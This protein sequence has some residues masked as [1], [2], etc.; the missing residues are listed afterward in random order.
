MQLFVSFKKNTLFLGERQVANTFFFG[1]ACCNRVSVF[2]HVF[3]KKNHRF[4]GTR[5]VNIQFGR[6]CLDFRGQHFSL[7]GPWP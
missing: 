1:E 6:L 2:F 4:Y 3:M 5:R 7:D